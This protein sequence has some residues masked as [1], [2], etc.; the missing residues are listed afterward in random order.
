MSSLKDDSFIFSDETYTLVDSDESLKLYR[1]KNST[2]KGIIINQNGTKLIDNFYVPIE[3]IL[4][5]QSESFLKNEK[6]PHIAF[7]C[8]EGTLVRIYYNIETKSWYISTNSRLDA[9]TSY[10]SSRISFGKQ[11][12]DYVTSKFNISFEKFLESLNIEEKYFFI[13]PTS[14]I[15][16]LGKK[17]DI[18]EE[19][20]IYLVGL[21]HS[22]GSFV[23]GSDLI[24]LNI[25][26]YW[27]YL[28]KYEIKSEYDKLLELIQKEGVNLTWYDGKKVVKCISEEYNKR[29][30]IRNNEQNLIYRYIQLLKNPAFSETLEK[31]KQM[32]PDF[33][34]TLLVDRK[35]NTIANYIHS[36]YVT[37]YIKKGYVLIPKMFFFVMKKCHQRYLS[38]K[39][40]TTID[41]IKKVIFEQ[42]T[43]LIT[44]LIRNFSWIK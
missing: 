22:D 17:H 21:E 37:R 12:E 2:H 16:R 29:C 44:S 15:N 27:T 31:L 7:S 43:K 19:K 42:D 20:T 30:L 33:K 41:I 35:I 14:G 23:C 10:W 28:S 5:E 24:D 32:Y 40:K 36:N 1:S 38:T 13:L 25:N 3:Y 6:T 4:P 11:F 26:G 18:N 9:Y 34:F 39:E 8:I